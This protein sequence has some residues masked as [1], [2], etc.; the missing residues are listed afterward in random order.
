MLLRNNEL[1]ISLGIAG[2]VV[3]VSTAGLGIYLSQLTSAYGLNSSLVTIGCAWILLTSAILISIFCLFTIWHYHQLRNLAARI[4]E[5]LHSDRSISFASM[6]EGEL[7]ILANE[8]DKAFTRLHRTN[9]TLAQERTFLANSLADISHQL[10]TPLT[11]LGLMLALA[12][13]DLKGLS[14]TSCT[15]SQLALNANHT[16]E[17]S[18]YSNL[19]KHVNIARQLVDQIQWLVESLLTLARTDADAIALQHEQVN[20]EALVKEAIA[21]FEVAF[22]LS[23]IQLEYNIDP[24]IHFVGDERWTSEALKNILKNCLEHTKPG[25]SISIRA[26]QDTL[27]C[28]LC[29]TDTGSGFDPEDLP[30]IFERFYR[31]KQRSS[32]QTTGETSQPHS[33]SIGVGIGLALA[34]SL[35]VAQGGRITASNNK[36]P[37][38]SVAGARFDIT[39]FKAIV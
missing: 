26:S 36:N 12:R 38:G 33:V 35:I 8:I 20:V 39:F 25:G 15:P 29:I 10:R 17:D 21:P 2:G 6:S 30:H 1:K 37:D 16:S 32:C 7:A 11:S 14:E 13:K 22:E 24:T 4:D 9:E 3:L 19:A 27:A 18:C 31:G 34:Q 5:A 28:R 23:Q